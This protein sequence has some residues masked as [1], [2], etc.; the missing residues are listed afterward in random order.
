MT[1]RNAG[2]RRAVIMGTLHQCLAAQGLLNEQIQEASRA[3]GLEFAEVNVIYLVRKEAA[4]AVIGKQGSMLKQIREASGARITLAKDEI[5]GLRPCTLVGSLPA[6]V[7]AERSIFEVAMQ[8][9]VPP[10][11]G[12]AANL[13]A[14]GGAFK[15]GS[16]HL[17]HED[18]ASLPPTAKRQR[19]DEDDTLT[20]L[21]VPSPSAGAVIGKQ[22]SGLKEIRETTGA[23]VE[24]LQ[25]PQAPQWPADRVVILRG[26]VSARQAA[27]SAVLRMAFQL[28]GDTCTLKLLVSSQQAGSVIG[29]QASTLR[30]IREQCGVSVQV[31]REEVLGDRLVTA[32]GTHFQVSNAAAAILSIIDCQGLSPKGPVQDGPAAQDWSTAYAPYIPHS[33]NAA[34]AYV[35]EPVA[36][37]GEPEHLHP[38]Y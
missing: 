28:Y 24:M 37:V 31:D 4:G 1:D 16:A 2:E 30:H 14:N 32:S 18:M 36:P 9:P 13:T 23:Q 10:A 35:Q 6:V 29:K 26:A 27:V 12:A 5:E 8:A 25:Q 33:I 15:S 21:L 3:A 22:G 17:A 11:S 34:G 7:Q 19:V 20:K 38:G